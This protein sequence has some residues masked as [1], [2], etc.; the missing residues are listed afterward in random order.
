MKRV[1]AYSKMIFLPQYELFIR[2]MKKN[3]MKEYLYNRDLPE[4]YNGLLMGYIEAVMTLSREF[5][6]DVDNSYITDEMIYEKLTN[7]E[8]YR[9][10]ELAGVSV[11]PELMKELLTVTRGFCM[12]MTSVLNSN[13]LVDIS[14]FDMVIHEINETNVIVEIDMGHF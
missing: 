12:F 7:C 3:G 9:L 8:F 10:V 14:E 13:E 4:P 2:F 5:L 6:Y 11:T 1:Y